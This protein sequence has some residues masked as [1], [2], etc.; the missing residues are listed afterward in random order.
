MILILSGVIG[1]GEVDINKLEIIKKYIHRMDGI[2]VNQS[3]I[4]N[5]QRKIMKE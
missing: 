5:I 3:T 4:Q 1:I 2:I